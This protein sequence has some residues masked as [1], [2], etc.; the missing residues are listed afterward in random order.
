[1][2]QPPQIPSQIVDEAIV[3]VDQQNHR[4]AILVRRLA[5]AIRRHHF[6][7][8]AKSR[9]NRAHAVARRF[10]TGARLG[11]AGARRG[12]AEPLG[13]LY[14]LGVAGAWYAMVTDVILRSLLA[15]GIR[16][17][18][19]CCGTTEAHIAALRAA[20][21]DAGETANRRIDVGET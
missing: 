10:S 12:I 1:M 7:I 13:R 4:A 14:R 15:L 2:V 18:G 8:L 17:I 20:L 21:D 19:G 5:Y 16:L 11:V 6:S 9:A 3:I